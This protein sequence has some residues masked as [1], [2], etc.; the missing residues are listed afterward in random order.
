VL[1]HDA[2]VVSNSQL[3]QLLSG[4]PKDVQTEILRINRDASHRSL[5]IAMLVPVIAGLLGLGA[6]F[7]MV[8]HPDPV[9]SSSAEGFALG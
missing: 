4:Q 1:E 3:E 8:R 7:R 9:S 6:S 5:Q 2:Q